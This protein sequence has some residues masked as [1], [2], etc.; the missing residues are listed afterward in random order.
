MQ[1]KI[2]TITNKYKDEIEFILTFHTAVDEKGTFQWFLMNDTAEGQN[3]LIN[4]EVFES[5]SVSSKWIKDNAEGKLLGFQCELK[6]K[7]FTE[8]ICWLS[9][10]LLE[11]LRNNEFEKILICDENGYFKYSYCKDEFEDN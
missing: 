10:D 2:L 9:S 4:G 3:E 6:E 7:S 1:K 8:N 5:F 11:L